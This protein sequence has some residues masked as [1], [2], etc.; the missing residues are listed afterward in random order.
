MGLIGAVAAYCK[1]RYPLFTDPD[2]TNVC[3]YRSASEL[4]AEDNALLAK[5]TEESNR[6]ITLMQKSISD[7]YNSFAKKT[8]I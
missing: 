8:S 6:R 1:F 5:K 2:S 3:E 4:I 7:N